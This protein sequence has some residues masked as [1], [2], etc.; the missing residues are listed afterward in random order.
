MGSSES[1]DNNIVV[2]PVQQGEAND[3]Y[4]NMSVHKSTLGAT[5]LIVIVML[6]CMGC[7]YFWCKNLVNKPGVRAVR[8]EI[9]QLA[10]YP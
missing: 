10:K 3:G 7:C 9:D 4:H 1:K 2:V 5:V 8:K 6:I